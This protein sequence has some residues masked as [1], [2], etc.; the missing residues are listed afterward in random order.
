MLADIFIKRPR[1]AGVISIVLFLAGL[2]A[3]R[4][5]PVEQFP[6][7]V[8]PQVSVT[9]SYPGAG[10]EVVEQ[11]V[12]QVIEDQIVGVDNMIYMSSTSGADGSY[13][14]T[15]SFEVGTDPDIAT[16]NVQ[17][18]VALA[19]PLLPAEVRQTGVR[20]AKKSSSLLMGIALYSTS[21]ALEG[22][23]LTNYARLNLMDRLK[24]V[25]GVGDASMFGANEFAMRVD[26]DV[27]RLAALSLT[28]SDVI[29]ALKSQNLQAAI[30]RVGGQPV[31][32]DPGLQLNISTT[33]RL[34]D[35]E[36]FGAIILRAGSDGSVLRIR[37][38]ARVS[39]GE[40]NSD[41]VTS[42]DGKPATLIGLYL[43]PGGNAVAAADA[44]K[45]MMERAAADFP[46]GMGYGLVADSSVFVKESIH[47]VRKT[48]IEAFVLV[49]LVVFVF[50][51]SLRATLVPLI[52]VPVAL[53]GTFAVMQMMGFSLN[54][55]SL[56]AMVLAIGIVV[57]DPIVVVE[58][59]E[60]KMEE[61]P[62]MSPAEASSAAMSE[63]TGAIVATTLVLLSVFVPVAFI[64][65]ISGQLFQ[66]FA[67]AVSVSMVISSINAL[68]LSPALCAILL[69]P[70]HGPKRGIMGRI[71]RAI[72]G[73]RDGY[74]RVAGAIARRA[75]L[76]LVL[77]G[78]AVALT[79]GLFK[80]VPT[81]FLP[82]E[83]QGSF[84]VETR[85]PEAASVNRTIAAQRELEAILSALPGVESVVSV[86]GYSMLDGITKSNAAF[87]LVSMQDFAERTTPETSAFHAIEQAMRQGAAIRSAQVIAFNLPPIAGLGTGSGFEMQLLDT[88]GRSAQELAETAR[89]LSFAANGDAR[90][91]GVY[92]TF[93]AESPQLFLEIDRE[94][95]YALGMSVS[96]VFGALS[97]TLGSAYVND[98]N[99]FG[100]S[101]QVRMS[102]APE[103]R[104][105]VDDIARIQ[106]RSAS[107]E[108]VPVGAFARAEYVTG[109]M[110]LSR[111]NNQRAARISGD[112][113]PGLSSGAALVAM[114]EVA[115]QS[116]PAGFDYEW[117]GT[118]L[119]E[120]QAAGQTTMI[121][122]LAMLF[123]YLFLVAL[124]ESWTIPVSVM[125]SVVF[126]VAGAMAA[127]LV[128]G[129]PFNIYAQIGLV[130]L[131]ALAAKNAILIVEF[132]KARR[133]EGVSILDA[134]VQGAGARF[135][136]V[137]MTSF[138]FIAGL[139]P[140]VTAEGASMLS[141]R[142]VGTGVAGG[143]LAAAL[144]GIFVIPALY[145][146]F[147]SLRERL[148]GQG[149]TS[150]EG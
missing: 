123:A 116:L 107:G 148:K 97:P 48:L 70:H 18:R 131:L 21:E 83:D 64:P 49:V 125:L 50:L 130:V 63:I 39:L 58:A 91:S 71:S 124:Y 98:F 19:E 141:R 137:M 34:S 95:L 108:M 44:V 33:G 29:G 37:D 20:V 10:A 32:E 56:L 121:L 38:V 8:P 126:G 59:V 93:S 47:E 132:A 54:T 1:F 149:G 53:V 129:L 60:A 36:E 74:A 22:P 76:G 106:V 120:K 94:R 77:L 105:A 143:M 144:I 87:S 52:A 17:N 40:K 35:P 51:G 79:G 127:L 100:R 104:D 134:A 133:E 92:S 118:A 65:G 90:L 3:L 25:E 61:N 6:D 9:A 146:V 109:P 30:G 110:S 102:A 42:F 78:G 5:M 80:V 85:L 82:A 103:F 139:I 122:A 138:A 145:V 135:R 26:L 75:I 4:Q 41:V 128:A 101:W 62:G 2:I 69:K 84:I 88:Q 31:T 15:I 43:A 89:G 117:T 111:Y 11:T 136:A 81:G 99:L 13:G 114:E 115:A 73:A 16:V 67:V 12:A 96:D 45:A 66:Q 119:Q 23:D 55:V 46:A 24:R 150:A 140:L 27:D 112:P 14:L 147:Q 57:D 28:P 113:A 7:I 68:T 142:A 72:D 86:M